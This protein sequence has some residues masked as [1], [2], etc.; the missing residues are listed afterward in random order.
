MRLDNEDRPYRLDPVRLRLRLLDLE[1]LF[2]TRFQLRLLCP[3]PDLGD[4]GWVTQRRSALGAANAVYLELLQPL[5][6]AKGA[7]AR[8][9]LP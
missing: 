1:D 2:N 5:G 4:L 3:D 6:K 8:I 7:F 9:R